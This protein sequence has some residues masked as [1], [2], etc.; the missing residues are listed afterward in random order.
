MIKSGETFQ[1]LTKAEV[2]ALLECFDFLRNGYKPMFDYRS[3]LTWVIKLQ[4]AWNS[5]VIMVCLF[6]NSYTIIKN[7]VV[8]KT[9]EVK[10]DKSR[11]SLVINTDFSCGVIRQSDGRGERV[12]SS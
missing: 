3:G 10:D 11:Y 12:I 6:E 2:E 4:H 8:R 1:D 9:V 7:G 5:S